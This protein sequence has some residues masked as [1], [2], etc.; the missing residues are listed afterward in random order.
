MKSSKISNFAQ[1]IE[2]PSNTQNTSITSTSQ[3]SRKNSE[4]A[5]SLPKRVNLAA[6]N[7]T[8]ISPR[9]GPQTFS[10][11]RPKPTWMMSLEARQ[12][13]LR[14][15]H[16]Q[17]QG[18]APLQP[19]RAELSQ[20]HPPSQG[21][22]PLKPRRAESSQAHP[23]SQGVAPL[24]PRRV[25]PSQAHPASQVVAPLKPRRAESSQARPQSQGV[26]P[27][28]SLRVESSPAHLQSQPAAIFQRQPLRE[29]DV[30]F[31]SL[32]LPK[33]SIEGG[34]FLTRP[35]IPAEE[36]ESKTQNGRMQ[37]FARQDSGYFSVDSRQSSISEKSAQPGSSLPTYVSPQSNFTRTVDSPE[38]K[39]KERY[40]VP[41][42]Q[43]Q[44]KRA[45]SL[46]S[47]NLANSPT[48]KPKA[49]GGN[50][51]KTVGQYQELIG[52]FQGKAKELK[53]KENVKFDQEFEERVSEH[54]KSAMGSLKEAISGNQKISYKEQYELGLQINTL[55]DLVLRNKK[56]FNNTEFNVFSE[57]KQVGKLS[58]EKMQ[59]EQGT[60]VQN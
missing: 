24:Q 51:R 31:P 10:P 48:E 14:Q 23:Q 55:R 41:N 13:E 44:N 34:L 25:E 45:S 54:L 57:A 38:I 5:L 19:R 18:V 17:S 56:H 2:R 60:W 27:L 43:N 7:Q 21:V 58:L 8:N 35:F 9:N 37:P 59:R 33:E 1:P 4:G 28:K 20:A 29:S 40:S 50:N 15:L 12:A 16:P 46:S 22:A 52:E 49:L 53:G 32:Q 36:M 47:P 11:A 42:L 3:N 6:N 39:Q 30:A 26:M